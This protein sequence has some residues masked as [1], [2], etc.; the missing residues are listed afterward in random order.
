[1]ARYLGRDLGLVAL[2]RRFV[3]ASS[4]YCFSGTASSSLPVFSPANSLGRASGKARTPPS[5]MSSREISRPSRSHA[6]ENGSG[7]G[8]ALGVVGSE[9]SDHRRSGPDQR[10]VIG[11]SAHL[12]RG[13]LRDAATEHDPRA[14]RELRQHRIER[15]T[16]HIVEEHVDAVGRVILQCAPDVLSLVIDGR[17]EAKV[18]RNP[19][20]FIRSACDADHPAACDLA[21]LTGDAPHRTSR[22]RYHDRLSLADSAHLE[23]TEIRGQAGDAEGPEIGRQRR[24]QRVKLGHTV[25]VGPHELLNPEGA[26]DMVP[27]SEPSMVSRQ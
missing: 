8:I 10:Q 13:V 21:D 6:S 3:Q 26:V 27:D 22:T 1:M 9:E 25:T 20:A 16:P 11:W 18:F 5:R 2:Q 17:V 15:L 24:E 12:I 7:F 14:T 23:Q 19:P 4:S